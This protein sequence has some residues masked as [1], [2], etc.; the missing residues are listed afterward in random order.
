MCMHMFV[1]RRIEPDGCKGSLPF[2]SSESV[3]KKE[4]DAYL[5]ILE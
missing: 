2:C 4:K 3:S 1:G 5:L